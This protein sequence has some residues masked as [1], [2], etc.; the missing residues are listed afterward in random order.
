MRKLIIKVYLIVLFVFFIPVAAWAANL[1]AL[2]ADFLQGNYRRVILEGL[3]QK[4][5][6]NIQGA[7]ELNYLLGLSYLKEAKLEQAQDC[8]RSILNNPISKFKEQ[9]FLALADIY[10]IKGQYQEA[11]DLYGK[12]L[13]NNPNTSFKAAILYR[14]S[15][16]G[17]RK[18][19]KEQFDEYLSKLKRDFPLSL[20]LRPN[21][22]IP[23]SEPF[24]SEST[25]F[26]VQVGFFGKY[27][28]AV[29]F[30]NKLAAGGYPAYIEG[31]NEGYRVKV[32]RFKTQMEALDTENKLSQ[33]G[34]S[35]KLCP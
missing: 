10:L 13:E 15:Q 18:G 24:L 7:D 22:G 9:A 23:R 33:D 34:F 25:E 11:E 4:G 1:D 28:N 21:R 19:N 12:L 5:H 3:A 2:K 20:E 6:F 31:S 29:N 35:T 32:G 26:S 16:L 8:L 17:Y 30:K 14:L 27:L